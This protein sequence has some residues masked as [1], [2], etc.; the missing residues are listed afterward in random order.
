MVSQT[1]QAVAK[2]YHGTQ[3]VKKFWRRKTKNRQC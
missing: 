3:Q 2:S 1:K